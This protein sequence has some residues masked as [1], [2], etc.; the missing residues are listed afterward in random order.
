MRD[1][2]TSTGVHGGGGVRRLRQHTLSKYDTYFCVEFFL[3]QRQAE[4]NI[5]HL[6][7]QSQ[8]HCDHHN[9]RQ[10]GWVEDAQQTMLHWVTQRKVWMGQPHNFPALM[11]S[12]KTLKKNLKKMCLRARVC[13]RM[14]NKRTDEHKHTQPTMSAGTLSYPQRHAKM[15]DHD[16]SLVRYAYKYKNKHTEPT[17]RLVASGLL[18]TMTELR[19]SG[20]WRQRTHKLGVLHLYQDIHS[21]WLHTKCVTTHVTNTHACTLLLVIHTTSTRC[22]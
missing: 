15:K 4:A 5:A 18:A 6:P 10:Q 14:W 7:C 13:T 16:W 12:R 9:G 22:V 11:T 17:Y 1:D 3:H 2:I 20:I 19:K 21:V 8:T